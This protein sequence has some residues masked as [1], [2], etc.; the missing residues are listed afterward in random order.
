MP[1]EEIPREQWDSFFAN[2]SRQYEWWLVT[3]EVFDAQAGAQTEAVNMPLCGMSAEHSRRGLEGISILLGVKEGIRHTIPNAKHVRLK[4][5]AEGVDEAL[6]AESSD[7]TMTLRT[8]RSA[9]PVE[10][11]AGVME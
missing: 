4:R 1:T 3:V 6:A 10:Q 2:F 11:A 8:L 5:T 7:E 9:I